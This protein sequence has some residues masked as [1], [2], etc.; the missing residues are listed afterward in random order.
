MCY[1]PGGHDI[2]KGNDFHAS[3]YTDNCLFNTALFRDA[4]L[5]WSNHILNK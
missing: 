2:K 4:E 3:I 5:P 1:V